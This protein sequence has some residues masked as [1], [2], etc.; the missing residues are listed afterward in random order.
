MS[1]GYT[2]VLGSGGARGM[3]HIGVMLYLEE[4]KIPIKAIVGCSIGAELGAFWATGAPAGAFRDIVLGL[5][6]KDSLKIFFPN[7]IR[8]G[9]SSGP[10]AL[11]FINHFLR[12]K[13]IQN[14]PIPFAATATD[15]HT[16]KPVMLTTGSATQAVRASIAIPGALTPVHFQGKLLL[17]G[18]VSAPLPLAWSLK[19]YG[20]PIIAVNIQDSTPPKTGKLPGPIGSLRHA[21]CLMQSRLV[22]QELEHSP[23]EI[24]I[25]PRVTGFSTFKFHAAKALINEGY[26][27]AKRVF[28]QEKPDT[29]VADK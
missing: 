16:G 5:S 28:E 18:A 23:P 19:T 29:G 26:R 10:G 25:E 9:F 13:D 2:I 15:Y 22:S 7:R 27:A 6:W 21:N 20:Y 12:G 3:A 14:F 11:Y 17:D 1:E 4:K 24:L 8:G